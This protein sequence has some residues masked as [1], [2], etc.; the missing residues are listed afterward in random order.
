MNLA[1]VRGSPLYLAVAS[2]TAGPR[3]VRA[4]I[5][6]AVCCQR[7]FVLRDLASRLIITAEDG[8]DF[9]RMEAL[10]PGDTEKRERRKRRGATRTEGTRAEKD[11]ELLKDSPGLCAE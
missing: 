10:N 6:N 1:G 11:A 8:A 7:S 3:Q 9:L 2:K 4:R 5:A